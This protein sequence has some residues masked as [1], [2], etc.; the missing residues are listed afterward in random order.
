MSL[1]RL[2]II[3]ANFRCRPL[4]LDA[5]LGAKGFGNFS[6]GLRTEV[7]HIFWKNGEVLYTFQQ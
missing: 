4:A 3:I 2:V 1:V 5:R 7:S 6:K